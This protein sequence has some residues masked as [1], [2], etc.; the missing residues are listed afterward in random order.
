ME[1]GSETS[2][3]RM[4][5]YNFPRGEVVFLTQMLL[6]YAVVITAL[7][8]LSVGAEH[9]TLWVALLSSCLGYVMPCPKIK[10]VGVESGRV[11][12]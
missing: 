5:G 9:N 4:C 1:T 8:N 11:A 7:I 10:K 12:V 2:R 6:I 3:W